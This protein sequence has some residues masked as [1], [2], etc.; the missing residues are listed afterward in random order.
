MNL[1]VIS[2]I[3]LIILGTK[4]INYYYNFFYM[5]KQLDNIEKFKYFSNNVLIKLIGKNSKIKKFVT[6]YLLS[7]LIKINYLIISTLI[8]LL[9]ALCE[10]EL[11]NILLQNGFENIHKNSN[12]FLNIE[13]DKP[14]INFIKNDNQELKNL[15]DKLNMD[16]NSPSSL[17]NDVDLFMSMI[18]LDSSNNENIKEENTI[19]KD[20]NLINNIFDDN[21]LKNIISSNIIDVSNSEKENDNN[22]NNNVNT[23]VNNDNENLED[24]INDE[25]II[26]NS[27]I[28]SNQ[29][30][31]EKENLKEYLDENLKEYLDENLKEYLD[32]DLKEYVI[33]KAVNNKNL[34]YENVFEEALENNNIQIFLKDDENKGKSDVNLVNN[35]EPIESIS[36]D[37]IDFGDYMSNLIKNSNNKINNDQKS[38]EVGETVIQKPIKIKIGKKKNNL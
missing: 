10:N 25:E 28:P 9:Y 15:N 34:T 21:L 5:Y 14:I 32:E 31:N 6:I 22:I 3:F 16:I 26:E 36:M 23:D 13:N 18:N 33:D 4:F 27:N 38:L 24:F 37:E 11:D 7:P 17:K 30:Q 35:D 20:T 2:V 19:K 12:D 8:Y 1:F 29:Q